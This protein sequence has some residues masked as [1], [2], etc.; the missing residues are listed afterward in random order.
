MT[1]KTHGTHSG[2]KTH[3]KNKEEACDSC[4]EAHRIYENGKRAE[5][6][7]RL[8]TLDHPSHMAWDA[9]CRCNR[10]TVWHS[11]RTLAY[12]DAH[13]EERRAADRARYAR[14]KALRETKEAS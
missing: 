14:L 9:G 5:R 2:Y 10:C 1:Q 11:A 12:D 6:A 13:R 3:R 4:K 7:Q 8:D